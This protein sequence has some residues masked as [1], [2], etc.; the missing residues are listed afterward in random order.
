MILVAGLSPAW[1]QI[2]VLDAFRVGEVNRARE[3][4]WCASGKALNVAMAIHRLGV[5]CQALCTAAGPVGTLLRNEFAEQ[6][7]ACEWIETAGST[8]VC[9]T[10]LDGKTQVTTELV[11]NASAIAPGD[12]N[13]FRE[14]FRSLAGGAKFVVLTGSLP[15]GAPPGLFGE[16]LAEIQV[17]ALVDAQ[18]PVLQQV[19]GRRP[20]VV[21][22]NREELANTLKRPLESDEDLLGAMREV[23]ASGPEWVIVSG[24]AGV[25][26]AASSSAAY[27][28][29]PPRV[30]VVN[31]IGSGDCLA[32]GIA[33]GL[34]AGES[35]PSSLGLGVAAASENVRHL[36]P[37]KLDR[38]RVEAL[39]EQVLVEPRRRD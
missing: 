22:P 15:A 25:L 33:C 37:A 18:G 7:V 12:L 39:R 11:E 29:H 1:Q 9:T 24:G 20:T 6:G 36:L 14:A 10:I 32:A 2:V 13:R 28:V 8:R 34:W 19:L 26:W 3:V 16:L 35:L 38:S 30:P 27:R 31:P 21:K 17:P 4:H 23:C 5:P